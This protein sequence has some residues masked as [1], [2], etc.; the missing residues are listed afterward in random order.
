MPL[1]TADPRARSF[2]DLVPEGT[3]PPEQI[4]AEIFEAA[5]ATYRERRRL[6]MR[7][8]AAQLKIGRATLYRKVG[9]RDRLLG[10]LMWYLTRVAMSWAL[11]EAGDRR[12]ADRVIEVLRRFMSAVNG[13]R[14]LRHFLESEPEAALRIL[15]SKHGP[16]QS[17]VTDALASLLAEEEERGTLRPMIDR[18]T[19]A[20]VIVRIGEGFLYADVIADQ[21]P[22]V[23]AAVEVVARLLREP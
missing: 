6:D 11:D 10:E 13:S 2:E 17:G 22:D 23:D 12:G 5:L 18:A 15:T 9:N 16:I 1:P 20:Y 7:A 8:L 4:P 3:A 14:E 19:L 21:E